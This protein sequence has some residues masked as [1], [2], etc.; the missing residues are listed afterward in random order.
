MYK[1]VF[2]FLLN[3]FLN[4][5]LFSQ[6]NYYYPIAFSAFSYNQNQI[7]PANTSE[8]NVKANFVGGYNSLVGPFKKVSNYYTGFERSLS[9]EKNTKQSMGL[10]FYN[11]RQGSYISV[12]R[13]YLNYSFTKKLRK[14]LKATAGL[15]LGFVSFRYSAPSSSLPSVNLPD[16]S[17]GFTLQSSRIQTSISSFQILNNQH[18]HVEYAAK[19]QRYF[20][21]LGQYKED[22]SPYFSFKMQFMWRILPY[23]SDDF[24]STL[25]LTYDQKSTIG[26]FY[27]YKKGTSFLISYTIPIE[28]DQL[29]VFFNYNSMLFT[30][31]PTWQTNVELG[32]S[33]LFLANTF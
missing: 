17:I 16:G 32:I 8:Q 33:Y 7:S 18:S 9:L 26:V 5:E 1:V 14:N 22:I 3:L 10:F 2:C 30:S 31:L 27:S 15:N 24:L 25:Y 23:I 4:I 21:F 29:K 6:P 28:Q 13:G 20:Q 11:E 19:L 12:P